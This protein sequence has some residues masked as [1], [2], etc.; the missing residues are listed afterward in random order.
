MY[1]DPYTQN[2]PFENIGYSIV[3]LVAGMMHHSTSCK[4]NE[5]CCLRQGRHPNRISGNKK[6]AEVFLHFDG[7]EDAN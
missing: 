7:L 4:F 5:I 3:G 1:G 6:T 2:D